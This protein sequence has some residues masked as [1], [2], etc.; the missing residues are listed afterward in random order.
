[1]QN[2]YQAAFS[3]NSERP[4]SLNAYIERTGDAV[5]PVRLLVSSSCCSGASLLIAFTF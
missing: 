3:A 5:T 1:M 4:M 2:G